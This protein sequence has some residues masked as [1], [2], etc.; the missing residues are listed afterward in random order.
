MSEAKQCGPIYGVELVDELPIGKSGMFQCMP[1]RNELKRVMR[2]SQRTV[3]A[4][5]VLTSHYL[6]EREEVER[7]KAVIRRVVAGTWSPTELQE[8]IGDL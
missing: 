5:E 7:L 2:V 4:Y 3:A 6:R 1:G 8:A